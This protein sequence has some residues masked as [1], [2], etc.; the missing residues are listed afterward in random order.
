M[1]EAY[2]PRLVDP[3][4]AELLA[5]FPAVLVVGPRACGKT[6]TAAR[7]ASTILRLD[8][9]AEAAAVRADPDGALHVARPV[10]LDEW[11]LVPEVLAAV[12]RAVDS[13][14]GPNNFLITGS[15]RSDLEAEGWPMTGRVLRVQMYGLTEREINGNAGAVPLLDRVAADG[16]A[17][18]SV[19]ERP[20]SLNDYIALALRGGFPEAVLA[21]SE[22][23]RRQWLR[24]YIE[25]LI[26]RDVDA[27]DGGRDPVRLRRYLH[28]L[29]LNSAGVVDAKTLYESAGVN[30]KTALAYDRLLGNLLVADNVPAWWTNRLKRLV[31]TPKRYVIDPAVVGAMLRLDLTGARK[32]GD[33]LG[34]L[35]DTFVMAQLRAEAIVCET[36]P[37][38]YHLRTAQGRHEV[39]IVVEYGDG[40]VFGIEV[41]ASSG[42]SA[43]DAKH[44]QWLHDELGDRFIG[45][46]VLH[47]GPRIYPLAELIVAA[48]ICSLWAPPNKR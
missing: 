9:E 32:D 34:R 22:R 1:V 28:V 8:R 41:K 31:Q 23:V 27:L 4:I 36:E 47:S 2:V 7:Y 43:N 19:P 5:G 21:S 16:V 13:R 17:A 45:G 39:D 11:Q 30:R 42:P 26:T 44:L 40:R 46:V 20:P 14:P 3:L 35:L 25:Q 33:L 12:K 37:N 24:A 29:C 6:T 38:L 15:V 10:L 18:F 48:P